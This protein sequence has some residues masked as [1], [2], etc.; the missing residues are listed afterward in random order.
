MKTKLFQAAR[1]GTAAQTGP[2]AGAAGEDKAAGSFPPC[3]ALEGE[4]TQWLLPDSFHGQP[5][6]RLGTVCMGRAGI[7]H[8]FRTEYADKDKSVRFFI[9]KPRA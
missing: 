1:S 4:N 9:F 6:Q 3:L 2:R 8:F 7:D 5:L